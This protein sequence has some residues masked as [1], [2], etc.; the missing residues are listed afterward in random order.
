LKFFLGHRWFIAGFE[1]PVHSATALVPVSNH[2]EA[3]QTLHIDV[4]P[5]AYMHTFDIGV[6]KLSRA[7]RLVDDRTSVEIGVYGQSFAD[8]EIQLFIVT[9]LLLSKGEIGLRRTSRERKHGNCRDCR[10][11][12]LKIAWLYS[13]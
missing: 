11:S 3:I 12:L 13:S 10:W 9:R 8:I 1:N 2:P 4:A 6:G 7:D 5:F